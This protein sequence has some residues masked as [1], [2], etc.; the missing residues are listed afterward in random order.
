MS[1][2]CHIPGCTAITSSSGVFCLN[3]LLAAVEIYGQKTIDELLAWHR[4]PQPSFAK[5]HEQLLSIARALE[6]CQAATSLTAING[7]KLKTHGE[8]SDAR[9]AP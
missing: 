3:H 7:S 1:D 5:R 8:P 2:R 4:R 9:A 6:R